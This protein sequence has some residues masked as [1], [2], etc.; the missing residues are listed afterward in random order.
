MILLLCF[1]FDRQEIVDA[2][3]AAH[4]NNHYVRVGADYNMTMK[5]Q[6][7]D[8][9]SCLKR[10]LAGGVPVSLIQGDPLGPVYESAGRGSFGNLKG[11]QHSKGL[12][13]GQYAFI[14]SANWTL[15]SRANR[16]I[17]VMMNLEKERGKHDALR[18]KFEDV[19]S[20]GQPFS[21]DLAVSALRARS[22]SPAPKR[23]AG[24]TAKRFYAASL[25]TA[26]P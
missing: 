23:A 1:S 7:R 16:E 15:S 5:G 6:T 21:E 3:L 8:Q 13:C 10:L 26:P 19:M 9:L 18:E 14:G 17:T 20:Y 2:L 25:L 24:A 11:I 22:Q 4:R 12:L